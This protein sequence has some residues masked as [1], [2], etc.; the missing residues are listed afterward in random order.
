MNLEK[1]INVT[2][3][4]SKITNDDVANIYVSGGCVLDMLLGYDPYDID[5]FIY[6]D[7]KESMRVDTIA[8][9]NTDIDVVYINTD[10]LHR[11]SNLF[12]FPIKSNY[13][14]NGELHVVKDFNEL[15]QGELFMYPNKDVSVFR[16]IKT[17]DKYGF[18]PDMKLLYILNN[19][20]LWKYRTRRP[21]RVAEKYREYFNTF[22]AWASTN[23]GSI[24]IDLAMLCEEVIT[25]NKRVSNSNV[26]S[27]KTFHEYYQ[28]IN[29]GGK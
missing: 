19:Y 18:T 11:I 9:D 1:I 29:I 6:K 17:A 12:D 24:D 2:K 22:I 15:L 27:Y 10:P 23:V 20:L 25:H 7:M 3:E 5:V 28:Y 26:G 21:I 14:N 16:Y 4:I 13:V 8:I